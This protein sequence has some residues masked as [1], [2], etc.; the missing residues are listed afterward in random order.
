[1][2]TYEEAEVHLHVLLILTLDISTQPQW[3]IQEFCSGGGFN[4]F[5]LGQR[6]E[7]TGIW[8]R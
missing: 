5:I 7:R 1:M 2:K 3:R 6:T 4:K 8:G